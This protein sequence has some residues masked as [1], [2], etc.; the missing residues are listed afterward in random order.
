MARLARFASA[1]FVTA[2]FAYPLAAASISPPATTLS[3]P[4]DRVLPAEFE[5]QDALLL[6]WDGGNEFIQRTLTEIITETWRTT[7]ILLLVRDADDQFA[8]VDVLRRAGLSRRTV[9]FV[10]LPFDSIWSRDYG[11]AVVRTRDGSLQIIDSDYQRGERPNDDDVPALLGPQ[12]DIP[13]IR[14][15]LAIEGGNLI[16]NGAGLCL[17]TTKVLEQNAERGRSELDVRETLRRFYGASDTIFLE[18][19]TGE[20]TGHV[21]MFAT[22]L[23]PDTVLVGQAAVDE[24]AANAEIL[25]RNAGRLEG[26]WTPHGP[27]KVVRI[28]MPPSQGET[29]RTYTNVLYANGTILVP[30]YPAADPAGTVAA[31]M[32]YRKLL[33]GHRIVSI[34]CDQ[35]IELGGALHCISRNLPG[36]GRFPP[37]A[38]PQPPVESPDLFLA[39][40]AADG[41]VFRRDTDLM[42]SE[43]EWQPASFEAEAD[44]AA[45]LWRAVQDGWEPLPRQETPPMPLLEDAPWA[46][47]VRDPAERE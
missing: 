5:R 12:L 35:L 47:G 10:Q 25:D 4:P 33:P 28:P 41:P 36:I 38:A 42:E 32:L 13:A 24:D 22:F 40:R 1:L 8:A 30:A 11:P 2:L 21:D 37:E 23:A 9:R 16:S 19:L 45:G 46:N 20:Q 29:W 34:D 39:R 14:A 6:A 17:T 3:P 27:L 18:P 31:A 26:A 7:P 44:S 15:P 43:P